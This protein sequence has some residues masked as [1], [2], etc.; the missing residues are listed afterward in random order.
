MDSNENCR[1]DLG[2]RIG[3]RSLMQTRDEVWSKRNGEPQIP[4][5]LFCAV[6]GCNVYVGGYLDVKTG[7]FESK[8]Y[9]IPMDEVFI[10]S[11]HNKICVTRGT[12]DYNRE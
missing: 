3:D 8:N 5:N 12:C 6:H 9:L 11:G 4:M 2:E 10:C 1:G 7:Q